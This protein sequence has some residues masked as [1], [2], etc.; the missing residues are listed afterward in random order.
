VTEFRRTVVAGI[1]TALAISVPCIAWYVAG[2][3]ASRQEVERLLQEPKTDARLEAERLANQ[4]QLRLESMRRSE[5][6]R[7]PYD[8]QNPEDSDPSDCTYEVTV[9]SSLA[10]GPADPLIWTHFQMDEV[11]QLTIPTETHGGLAHGASHSPDQDRIFEELECATSFRLAALSED[12]DEFI[13]ER[14]IQTSEGP[15][16][17]GPFEWFTLTIDDQ[18]SLVALRTV[19]TTSAVLTQGF[20][21]L[22]DSLEENLAGSPYEISIEPGEPSQLGEG[23]LLLNNQR[24]TV[25]VN[26]DDRLAVAARKADKIVRRFRLSFVLG[27][28]GVSLAGVFLVGLVWQADRLAFRQ[29]Q[30]A[31]SAAHELRTPLAGLQLYAEMLSE[32]IGNPDHREKYA[33][34]IA[35]EAERLGRVVGNVMG[36]SRL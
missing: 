29:S 17:L 22:R 9:T 30:F 19:R 28:L 23:M 32:G 36:Y 7:S 14:L 20:V 13:E 24:W 35:E 5:S 16:T 12:D 27:T 6:R 8:Y 26:L 21:V 34:R 25:R 1:V 15:T 31:A 33:R 18:P 2:S 10:E 11:G 4:L 3:R